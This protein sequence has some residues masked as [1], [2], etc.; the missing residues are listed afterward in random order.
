MPTTSCSQNL[1]LHLQTLLLSN[2][3]WN[4]SQTSWLSNNLLTM[5]I[6]KTKLMIVSS[7]I[8]AKSNR[9]GH[10][11]CSS[12]LRS[13]SNISVWNAI[14]RSLTFLLPLQGRFPSAMETSLHNSREGG[15]FR[16]VISME[17]NHSKTLWENLKVLILAPHSQLTFCH[18]HLSK[19]YSIHWPTVYSGKFFFDGAKYF[20][21]AISISISISH[22][23]W[24]SAV[25]ENVVTKQTYHVTFFKFVMCAQRLCR[26]HE[27]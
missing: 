25:C 4:S 15:I 23:S 1:S 10:F 11:L 17:C 26:G 20:S 16:G 9:E 8:E 24:V 21:K 18:L 22:S 3:T 7:Q 19:N 2:L 14:I 27:G 13:G 5:K 6:N 12:Y